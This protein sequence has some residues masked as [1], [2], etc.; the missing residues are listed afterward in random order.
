MVASDRMSAFDVM[1]P[2]R[3]PGQGQDPH[4][5]SLWWFDQLAGL[6]DSH[7]FRPM[8]P[9]YPAPF[10]GRADLAGRSMFIRRLDMVMVECVARAYLSGSG[11]R[12]T[13]RGRG[14]WHAVAARPGRGLA[15]CPR[16]IFTPTT[17]APAGEH[18]EPMT[19]AEVVEGV[20]ADRAAELREL[21]TTILERARA[22]LR[23]ARHVAGRHQGRVRYDA[24]GRL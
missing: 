6:I 18:D 11:T 15:V 24:R 17:K 20:G 3:D 23:A 13:R 5:L 4:A 22:D 12:S 21:T 16:S 1:L 8:L 10:T 7:S 2:T 9:K 19:Y 14:L